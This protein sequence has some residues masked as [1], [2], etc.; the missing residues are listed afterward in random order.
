MV[1]DIKHEDNNVIY[2]VSTEKKRKETSVTL[3]VEFVG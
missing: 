1:V 3:H 2:L